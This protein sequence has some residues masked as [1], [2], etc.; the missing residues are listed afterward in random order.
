MIKVI[1][2]WV[3]GEKN[4]QSREKIHCWPKFT[5]FFLQAHV[6]PLHVWV[7]LAGFLELTGAGFLNSNFGN[8]SQTSDEMKR[9]NWNRTPRVPT[10]VWIGKLLSMLPR[11]FWF[12]HMFHKVQLNSDNNHFSLRFFTNFT[13]LLNFPVPIGPVCNSIWWR[14]WVNF[15]VESQSAIN[16]D[17]SGNVSEKLP[18]RNNLKETRVPNETRKSNKA[19]VQQLVAKL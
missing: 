4:T 16:F 7:T 2:I 13:Y 11:H 12:S 9:L 17:L 8:Y 14:C 5:K 19:R 1:Y 18:Y 6:T 3:L 10:Q 15:R